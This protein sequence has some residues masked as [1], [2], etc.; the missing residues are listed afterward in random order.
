MVMMKL[1][2]QRIVASKFPT[3]ASVL[4]VLSVRMK[5]I[6]F[7]RYGVGVLLAML[8][9]SAHSVSRE[10]DPVWQQLT[11]IDGRVLRI[12]RVI[13]NQSLLDM[14]QRDDQLQQELNRLRGQLEEL[15]HS[16]EVARVQFR[17]TVADLDRRVQALESSKSVSATSTSTEPS[18]NSTGTP[19]GSAASNVATTSTADR[20]AYQAAFGLLKDGKYPEA[21]TALTQFMSNYPQSNYLDNAQYWL[22]EAHYF[23]KEYPVALRDFQAVLSKYPNS[24]K[25]PDAMLKLGFTQYELKDYKAARATLTRLTTQYSDS[26]AA[27]LAQQRLAKMSAEGQ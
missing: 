12:E 24:A 11:E 16:V 4:Q 26:K 14:A 2:T 5:Q 6:H 7:N 17:D 13:N 20:D 15:Q 19:A 21:I 10:K 23:G 3:D 9:L 18:A 22:G 27:T 1:R 8:S 25:A